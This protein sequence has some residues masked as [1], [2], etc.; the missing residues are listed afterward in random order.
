MTPILIGTAGWTLP[1]PEQAEFPADG[2]HLSR[3]AARFPVA[4]I[5]SSFHRPHR[6]STWA[7]W[8]DEVPPGFRFSA[9]LPKTITH[10][11]KLVDV[12]ALLDTFLGE[13]GA[14]GDRLA[15]LLVQLPPSLELDPAVAERFF[16]ALRERTAAA[17]ACEP[18]HASWFSGDADA[19]LAGLGVARVA[20]DPARVPAAAE[21]GGARDVV[22]HRL[23]G[24]PRM[25]YSAYEGDFVAR[26]AGRLRADAAGAREVWCI[27][28]NTAA[29][30]ATRNALDLLG[31][32]GSRPG[33]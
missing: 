13:A 2:S 32:L 21:P 27:F 6:V 25:Y 31:V 19:L 8:A 11:Q 17:V 28:D 14:L 15:C 30:A 22:Y 1:K 33:A 12:E 24:S 5:N 3:Y 10:Q 9:K 4:E 20:A 7:R 18:R 23:H 16:L 26:L 29:G